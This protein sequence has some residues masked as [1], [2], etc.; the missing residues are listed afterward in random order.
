[1][2]CV[3]VAFLRV[4]DVDIVASPGDRQLVVDKMILTD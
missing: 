3:Y 1:M 4:S 2:C